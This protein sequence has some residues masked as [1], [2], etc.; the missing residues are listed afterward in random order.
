MPPRLVPPLA[1]LLL[2]LD[3]STGCGSTCEDRLEWRNEASP[4]CQ[5]CQATH[6]AD[7]LA[8]LQRAPMVCGAEYACVARCPAGS[9]STCDCLAACLPTEACRTP[10]E[11]LGACTGRACAAAC[12]PVGRPMD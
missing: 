6:C 12:G 3:G 1:A 11:A 7:E 9:A 2:A 10:Y 4:A 8:A 5:S